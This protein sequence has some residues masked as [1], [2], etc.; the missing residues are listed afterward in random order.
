MNEAKNYCLNQVTVDKNLVE[1]FA[2]CLLARVKEFQFPKAPEGQS[3]TVRYPLN[4]SG[5]TKMG[6]KP[7]S[8]E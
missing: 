6:A 8:A 7:S 3:V 1:D 5:K 2:N 4:F